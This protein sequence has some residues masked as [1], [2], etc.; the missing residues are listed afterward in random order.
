MN[1]VRRISIALLVLGALVAP[2]H[3]SAQ[4]FPSKPVKLVVPFAAGGTNDVFTRAMAPFLTAEWGQ[5]AIV[6]NRPGA[7]NIIAAESVARSAPDGYSLFIA[8]DPAL[9][10]NPLLYSKL[11]YDAI[12]DFAPVT[13]LVR[14][15]LGIVVNTS[16]P[17]TTLAEF[18]ALAKAKPGGYNYGSFGPGTAPHL[19]MELFKSVAGVDIVHVPYKGVA[20]VLTDLAAG[21]IQSSAMS[22]GAAMPQV[23][24]GRLRMLALEGNKRSPLMPEVPTFAEAGFPRMQAPA[25]W[26]VVAPAATP[27]PVIDRLNRDFVK[28]LNN[29]AFAEPNAIRHGYE[30]VGNTPEEFAAAIRDTTALWAPVIRA[31]NVKLD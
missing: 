30:P 4:A 22:A 14:F 26:G 12:K 10:T 15:G 21:V 7:G 6:E 3:A 13:L 8:S 2:L 31:A 28:V 17:A 9:A 18:V 20:P 19:V 27:R 23:K 24:G 29:P 25:W 5:P 11:P 16:V 1:P